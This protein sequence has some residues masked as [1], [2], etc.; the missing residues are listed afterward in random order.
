M[1][2]YCNS[3]KKLHWWG[4]YVESWG[5]NSNAICEIAIDT[6]QMGADDK[7]YVTW[8]LPDVAKTFWIARGLIF[9]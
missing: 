6:G 2:Y 1:I 3:W 8:E 9:F 4:D 7:Y 5:I